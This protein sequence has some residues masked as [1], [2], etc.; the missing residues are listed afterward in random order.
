MS[1]KSTTPETGNPTSTLQ[2][3]KA[4]LR[5]RKRK[6][7]CDGAKPACQQCTRAKKPDACEYDDGKGK[8]RTQI[9]RESITRLEQRIRELEDPEY[10]SPSVTL[11]DPHAEHRR[12]YSSS[13]SVADSQ[14][15]GLSLTNSPFPS[16]SP[17]SPHGSWIGIPSPSPSPFREAYHDDM[18][19]PFEL[20]QML[21]EI[22]L[23]HRHQCGLE[24]HIGRM[25]D[26]LTLP[27]SQQRHPILMNAI[28]LWSCY[29]SRPGPLSQHES[30]YLS[31][32][33][34]GLNDALQYPDKIIDVIQGS[35]LLSM[36]FLSNGRVLEGSYHANAA[37]SLSVQWGLHGGIS[38]APNLGFSDPISSC[39]LEPPRDAIEA[40]ERILAFWQVFNLDRCWSVI[41]HK[42]SVIPDTQSGFTSINTPWPLAMGE[43]ESGHMDEGRNFQTIQ[44][45]FEGQGSNL[46]GGFSTLALRVKASALIERANQLSM[47]WDHRL[48][49]STAFTDD[50]QNLEHTIT[51]FVPTLIPVQQLDATTPQNKHAFLTN[52]TLAH[53]AIIHLYYPFGTED[54]TSYEKCL[55]AARSIVTVIKHIS[56][57][58][59]DFLDPIIGPCWVV[60]ADTLIR[61]LDGIEVSWPLMNTGDIRTEI[62]TILY[63]MTSLNTR[64]PLLNFS[65]AKVQK[66][67]A[68]MI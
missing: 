34:E 66:R 58:D 11:F 1:T 39:K 43:Y 36:Y 28:F 26:S 12:S 24:V 49:P 51:R 32:A 42:P 31:R 5:C 19:P 46:V 7:R 8:T 30:H 38:N 48:A 33:L 6:M 47:N 14:G 25:R 64:F 53:A 68:D 27:P 54:P 60:A 40:G 56:E 4:C 37:A 59:F 63:A 61:E 17:N 55:R 21:L 57:V 22:F 45:F 41:L 15:S 62:G 20:A 52:H 13:S 10:T 44:T 67:L 18:R 65:V 16:E 50:F 23:P 3:G 2:R 29:V 35:C 9:L